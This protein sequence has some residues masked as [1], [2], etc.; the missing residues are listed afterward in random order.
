[1][2][3]A[4]VPEPGKVKT[5]LA[6]TIGDDKALQV[7]LALLQHTH[8][9]ASKVEVDKLLFYSGDLDSFDM[10]DYYRIPKTSQQGEGLGER[11]KN[12]FIR[13]FAQGYEKVIIMGSD[14]YELT[15]DIIEEGFDALE[16]HDFV[17]GPAADGGYY[18]LG[19]NN[20]ETLVFDNKTW[21]GPDVFLDTILDLK[22]K[23]ASYHL[24]PTLSDVDHVADMSD[25]LK[26]EVGI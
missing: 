2:I 26:K 19:M 22:A 3:F 9:V 20:L 5:R 21:S 4:K 14:C 11:M 18:M 15:S 25:E 24:L 23:K 6:E 12:A 7:Y 16:E 17:L 1:M 13:S 10:L 8:N